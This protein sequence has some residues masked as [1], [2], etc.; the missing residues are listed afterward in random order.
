MLKTE[1]F[2]NAF[3]LATAIL[4]II[5]FVL[6]IIAPPF[7]KLFLNSQVFGADIASQI[8]KLNFL[9]FLGT[10]IA[11]SIT[12]WIFGYMLAFIYNNQFKK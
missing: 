8:P 10:L 2:A 11:V 1:S 12:A 3:A 5:L 6:K 4:Y 7:F 9:N